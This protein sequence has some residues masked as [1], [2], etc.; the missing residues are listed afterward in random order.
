LSSSLRG[1]FKIYFEPSL[2]AAVL[3]ID[4]ILISLYSVIEMDASA[5]KQR[6]NNGRFVKGNS[7]GWKPGVSGNPRG[8][9]PNSKGLTQ[10]L[11]E[12]MDEKADYIGPGATPDD[13]TWRQ[14]IAKAIL[15]GCSRGDHSLISEL[16]D[17]LEGKITQP[18]D[19][20]VEQT[21]I[22]IIGKGN[23]ENGTP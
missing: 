7:C 18:I 3:E 21:A 1:I 8:K 19:A 20:K 5:K 9:P 22:W 6:E 2:Y 13:K 15:L 23:V 4:K 16:F 11:R 17:R 10:L 14:L 12:M